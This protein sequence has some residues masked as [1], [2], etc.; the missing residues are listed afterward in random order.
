MPPSRKGVTGEDLG[1]RARHLDV[2]IVGR[3]LD[4]ELA[5]A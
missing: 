4:R 1:R 5:A 3:P 2:G